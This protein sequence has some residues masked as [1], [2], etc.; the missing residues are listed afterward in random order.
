MVAGE[1]SYRFEA[2]Y[3]KDLYY[4]NGSRD[5]LKKGHNFLL[6][7]GISGKVNRKTGMILELGQLDDMIENNVVSKLDHRMIQEDD[8]KKTTTLERILMHVYRLLFTGPGEDKVK[9]LIC[10]LTLEVSQGK[11]IIF[12][13]VNTKH[14]GGTMLY[15]TQ[16]FNFSA[17]HFLKPN[18]MSEKE[19]LECYGKC[20]EL[21][22]HDYK[23]LVTIKGELNYETGKLI[24]DR[25]FRKAV[26]H[27]LKNY[28]NDCFNDTIVGIIPTTEVLIK[29]LYS[30]IKNVLEIEC[31]LLTEQGY[32]AGD[33]KLHGLELRETE[34][35]S[36]MYFPN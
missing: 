29:H 13:P 19:S 8:Q 12:L 23:L 16:V 35:N 28:R 30:E 4:E 9:S 21:H 18:N 34:R 6:R 26:K 5:Y 17:L 32:A 20:T 1:R 22:G 10:N 31:K 27:V 11:T 24:P 36:F 2:G 3:L 7:V 15:R 25:T 14:N 33:I